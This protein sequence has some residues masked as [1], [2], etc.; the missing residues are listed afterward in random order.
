MRGK[1]MS[2]A[3]ITPAAANA[4]NQ[5][6][7]ADK[8]KLINRLITSIYDEALRPLGITV[9]QM[10]ILVVVAKFGEA[11]P[12]QVV[13]WLHMEKSTLSRNVDRMRK[14]GW[15]KATP[16]NH[17]RSHTLQLTAKGDKV[18]EQGLPFWREAQK[19]ARVLLGEQGVKEVVCIARSVRT[20][21]V[22]PA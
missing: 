15:L 12:S 16:G 13:G 2:T 18:L 17:G 19:E 3:K 5:T 8:F 7:I 6:C 14:R 20:E 10:N 22:D 9:S 4:L 1:S 21:Q 11:S